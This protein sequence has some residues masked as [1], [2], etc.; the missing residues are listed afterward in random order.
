MTGFVSSD[1]LN[2]LTNLVQRPLFITANRAPST[3]DFQ[4]SGT[5]WQ[6]N[7]VSPPII[8]ETTGNGRWVAAGSAGNE[9]LSLTGNS[10][11]ALPTAG[12][13]QIAGAS[14]VTTSASGSI[15][16]VS[17][18]GGGVAIDSFVP[19]AGTNPVVPSVTGSVTM[20]GTANQLTTTGGLN[21][22]TFSL[23]GPYTPATYT[24]HGVLMGEGTSSIVA[25]SAGASG[26]VFTSAGASA[27]GAY[28]LLGFNSGL[29]AHGVVV[30]E[31]NSAFAAT[32]AG[33]TGQ[34]LLG[35]TGA[36]PVWGSAAL[37]NRPIVTQTGSFT[38]ALTDA[39]RYENCTGA[40][41]TIV[42]VPLNATIPFP[43]GTEIDFFQAGAGIVR[44]AAAGGVTINSIFSN[45]SV[46]NQFSGASLKKVD[47]DV[48]NLVGNLTA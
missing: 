39:N 3:L 9:V 4:N 33:T 37:V 44:F 17:L 18:T 47:T 28:Q 27:D 22:L 48:W 38:L 42:T 7:S 19:D 29:T 25:S 34:V 5:Q 36:D 30:A 10:G 23:A 31:G 40:A 13:I 46:A 12:N 32:G 26:Q 11:T 41:L 8:Y 6:D 20:A 45:L 1:P 14:G 24:A 15:V 2:N 16:T 43:V 21:S 35:V